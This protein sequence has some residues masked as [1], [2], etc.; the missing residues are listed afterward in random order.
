MKCQILFLSTLWTS[1]FLN[2]IEL[3]LHYLL[4]LEG[5][6]WVASTNHDNLFQKGEL[7]T[8]KTFINKNLFD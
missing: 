3:R 5:S 7:N 2:H 1:F 8:F 4:S 6:E